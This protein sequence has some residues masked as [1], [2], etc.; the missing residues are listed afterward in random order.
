MNLL[1]PNRPNQLNRPARVNSPAR[2][3]AALRRWLPVAAAGVNAIAAIALAF[4]AA[5]AGAQQLYRCDANGRT[6]YSDHPCDGG[7]Q[8]T[9]APAP[10]IRPADQAAARAR[11]ERMVREAESADARRNAAQD[12][13]DRRADE[14][15]LQQLKT[16]EAQARSETASTEVEVPLVR[17]HRRVLIDN[18]Y[19]VPATRPVAPVQKPVQRTPQPGGRI[20]L[21]VKP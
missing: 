11:G 20:N 16:D 8:S 5:P 2:A 21:V 18:R 13:A 4:A 15:R 1:R 7:Q 12:A 14:A 19:G 10:E 6:T 17:H 9:V 3:V